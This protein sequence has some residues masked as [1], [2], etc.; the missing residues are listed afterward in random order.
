[1]IKRYY[2][3]KKG[4]QNNV[5]VDS[6]AECEVLVSG[7]K[8]AIYKG[9]PF[10]QKNRAYQFAE[11]GKYKNQSVKKVK[12]KKETL[13]QRFNRLCKCMERKTYR[14][15]FT[16]ELYKN[17][18]IRRKGPTVRGINYQPSNDISVPWDV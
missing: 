8:G 12:S 10:N 7:F 18:C 4:H 16:G 9:F 2:A 1:M 17:R 13:N 15:P 6:W 5:V 14:D 11:F 3:I